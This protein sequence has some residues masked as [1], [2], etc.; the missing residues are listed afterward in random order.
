MNAARTRGDGRLVGN[1]T[2]VGS[3]AR[4]D[5]LAHVRMEDIWSGLELVLFSGNRW[6]G[7][8]TEGRLPGGGRPPEVPIARSAHRRTSEV[9]GGSVP[10]GLP[11]PWA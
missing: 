8:R 1:G 6:A 5:E 2:S 10:H 3:G 4:R 9:A 11:A 7:R